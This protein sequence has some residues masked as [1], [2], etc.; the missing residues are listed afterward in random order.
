MENIGSKYVG[1]ELK[2][3]HWAIK[4][5]VTQE[6]GKVFSGEL[7]PSDGQIL[8][9]LLFHV[10]EETTSREI[11]SIFRISKATCSENLH[12]SEEKGLILLKPLEEDKRVKK[13]ILTKK[14]KEVA[15][16]AH[17]IFFDCQEKVNECLDGEELEQMKGF[18]RKIRSGLEAQQKQ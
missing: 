15:E 14:G 11:C 12:R 7:T 17:Q 3:T 16:R 8:S 18:L 5:F 10:D 6:F 1:L 13:I 2:R 4:N 9:Y